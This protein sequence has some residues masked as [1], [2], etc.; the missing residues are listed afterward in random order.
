MSDEEVTSWKWRVKKDILN[1]QHLRFLAFLAQYGLVC[2]LAGL[3]LNVSLNTGAW[4]GIIGKFLLILFGFAVVAFIVFVI[5]FCVVE[6][7]NRGRSWVKIIQ[8][9]E[10]NLKNNPELK[11]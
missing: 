9:Y 4:F 7:W 5:A 3:A 8:G 1:N 11:K 6:F 10:Q 2:V